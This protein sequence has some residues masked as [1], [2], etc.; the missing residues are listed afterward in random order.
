MTDFL[1]RMAAASAE[2]AERVARVTAGDLDKPVVPLRLGAFELIAEIKERSPAA[3][4]LAGD[5]HD[6]GECARSYA[7]GGAAAISVLTEPSQFGGELAHLT[8]VAAAVPD[9]PV[10]CKDFLVATPQVLEARAAGASGVLL[11]V[12]MLDDRRLRAMLDAAFEHGLFV[13]LE[14]FDAD[15]L[16]RLHGFLA[17]EDHERAAGG[18]LLFGINTRN[19]R[20]LAVDPHR[21]ERLA[22][23]LPGRPAVAES[24]LA[25][26]ADA[27]AVAALGYSVALVGTALMRSADPAALV[28]AMRRAGNEAFAA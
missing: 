20:T 13:L 6:R 26:A 3:G 25:T 12:T 28:A 19:L 9:V 18:Q 21:L 14:S 10:M 8:E 1:S 17:A 22:G 27:A 23:A 2:R 11:I 4:V 5:G 7:A 24:G 15:D 16:E